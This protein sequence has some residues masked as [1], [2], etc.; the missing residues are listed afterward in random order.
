VNTGSSGAPQYRLVVRSTSLGPVAIQLN[1]GAQDLLA[2]LNTGSLASYTVNGLGSAIQSSSRTVTL[3]PGITAT[4]L[5]TTPTGQPATITVSR[6]LDA[7]G[8]AISGLVDAYN[9]V[10]DDLAKQVG[11]NAG[12]LSGQSIISTL[13]G[14][15][16]Q[17]T[18]Y[19]SGSGGVSSL[20][21]MG[22]N[23][24]SNG[25]LSFDQ[26]KFTPGGVA[27]L[28]TF[29]GDP[30]GQG[31]LKAVNDTLKTVEDPIT[32]SL[33]AE[34]K[35]SGDQIT[36]QNDL[37]SATQQKLSDMETTLEQQMAAADSLIASL[38]SKKNYFT[39]LFTA[40][41]NNNA[42]GVKSN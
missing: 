6:N 20:T 16:R 26:S 10:V 18:Q 2:N 25:H 23:L 29:L 37:I 4:L 14:A 39:N 5:Q 30:T 7:A 19:N 22:V 1:D 33:K 13:R 15:L 38:E 34:I 35:R 40:M 27:A 32:G 3:A 8:S 24:D 21:Q 31:F 42:S 11:Q 41:I 36:R 12:A 17:I 9:T 28:Q